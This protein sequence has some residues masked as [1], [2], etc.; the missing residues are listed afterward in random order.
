MRKCPMSG[1]DCDDCGYPSDCALD[2][3]ADAM[4]GIATNLNDIQRALGEVADAIRFTRV[5]Q[6]T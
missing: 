5:N 1:I 2:D 4:I 6:K 3:I